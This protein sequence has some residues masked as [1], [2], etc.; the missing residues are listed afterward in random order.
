MES[1]NVNMG[2]HKLTHFLNNI[3]FDN[4]FIIACTLLANLNLFS[5][6]LK[7][8]PQRRYFSYSWSYAF[9][10]YS[11]FYK[12]SQQFRGRDVRTYM[13]Y[14]ARLNGRFHPSAHNPC[15][16]P[17]CYALSSALTNEHCL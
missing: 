16:C 5:S 3:C 15:H 4:F 9:T 2:L 6:D 13:L 1:Q 11:I 17:L 14:S 12:G 10:Q 8:F 7:N